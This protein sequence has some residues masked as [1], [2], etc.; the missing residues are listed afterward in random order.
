MIIFLIKNKN[1]IIFPNFLKKGLSEDQSS[2]QKPFSLQDKSPT[3]F[4]IPLKSTISCQIPQ[5][6]SASLISLQRTP[7]SRSNIQPTRQIT[8]E[9]RPSAK[10]KQSIPITSHFTDVFSPL[11]LPNSKKKMD[12]SKNLSLR[13]KLREKTKKHSKFLDNGLKNLSLQKNE[14]MLPA[15]EMSIN[16]LSPTNFRNFNEINE[17]VQEEE[18][19][20]IEH[21][22]NYH[23]GYYSDSY[24]TPKTQA[25]TENET[26]LSI[27]DFECIRL[28]NKG[29]FGRVWLVKRK[30]TQ[31]FY[32]MKIVNILDHIINKKDTKF[33]EA[34]SRIYEVITGEFVV[35]AL[36]QFTHETFI[37]FVTEYM[38]GGDFANL[39]NEYKCLDE[40]VAKF[41]L[42]ELVLAIESLHS[43]NIIHRDLK[44]DN[45]LLDAEGHIKL[46][47]FGLSKLG[48]TKQ[49]Q[50]I[51]SPNKLSEKLNYK[52]KLPIKFVE[53]NEISGVSPEEQHENNKIANKS[54]KVLTPLRHKSQKISSQNNNL[55]RRHRVIGTPDYIAPEILNASD[56]W[57]NS[58]SVDWWALG[59]MIFEFIVGVP[60]FNDEDRKGIFD[61][62]LKLAIPWGD[63]NI[64]YGEDCMSPEAADL[65]KKMLVL[66]PEKRITKN[67]AGELKKH[68]FFKGFFL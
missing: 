3:A 53:I 66:D 1:F 9:I 61:N 20:L 43:A 15:S 40:T 2:Q 62:I 57:M 5:I 42:A 56:N 32:A 55:S 30:S 35:K 19:F 64:G 44:P 13:R 59:V 51:S 68:P 6:N 41:Y 54:S 50:E 27:K 67:G 7:T 58:P 63:I 46:T 65:I 39:L 28:I 16:L 45:I 60:P 23:R 33:L 48:I 12:S 26:S 22:L 4:E 47:D 11:N 8:S 52:L 14:S 31:D 37:C 17:V 29:A 10:K 18:E 38:L 36:F 25:I 21:F 24:L 34:E 49:T